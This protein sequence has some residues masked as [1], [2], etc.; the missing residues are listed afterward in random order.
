MTRQEAYQLVRNKGAVVVE[1]S[2]VPVDLIVVGEEELPFD[3]EELLD[4]DSQS[5]VA[6][7]QIQ[8]VRE[9]ELWE[10]LGVVESQEARSQLYTPAMLADLINVPVST[11]RR[12]HR[13]KLITPARE[14]KQLPYFDFREVRSARR[15]AQLLADGASPEVLERKLAALRDYFPDLERPLAQLTIM[16]EGSQILLRQGEGLVEPGGQLRFDFDSLEPS[17]LEPPQAV[18]ISMEDR[19]FELEETDPD[20]L[21]NLAADFEDDG[22]LETAANLLRAVMAMIGCQPELCFRLADLLFRMGDLT[23]AR[24]RYY[25]AIEIDED[26]VEARENL[27]CVLVELG[28]FDLAEA[29]FRGAIEFHPDYADAHFHLAQLLEEQENPESLFH[30]QEFLRLAPDSPWAETARQ[31]LEQ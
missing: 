31:R 29:A 2:S 20:H 12:W 1:N 18:T 7:G 22:E 21:L 13:R 23:A 15:L 17:D 8:L 30:W 4:D 24:E 26:Y 28:E 27:G 6:S 11:V 5:A 3:D 10:K 16:V 25:T 14:V 19:L 9:I